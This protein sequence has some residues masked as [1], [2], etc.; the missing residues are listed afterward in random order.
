MV[1]PRTLFSAVLSAALAL[2]CARAARVPVAANNSGLP[3]VSGSGGFPLT[4][5]LTS[6]WAAFD[7]RAVPGKQP[8]TFM[9]Y[10][11]GKPGWHERS[12]QSRFRPDQEPAV[13]EFASDSIALRADYRRATRVVYLFR[14]DVKVSKANVILVDHVDDPAGEVVVPL[15]RVSLEIPE[16]ENPAVHV[17]QQSQEIRRALL[18]SQ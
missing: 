3:R 13:V 14:S 8:L 15:G 18:P 7:E 17:L 5:E 10:F 11:R 4:A 2:G 1:R 12:W 6:M 9:I 16:D